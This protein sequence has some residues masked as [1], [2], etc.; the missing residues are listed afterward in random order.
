MCE[1]VG[2]DESVSVGADLH[3]LCQI[4]T[5]NMGRG[6]DPVTRQLPDVKLVNCQDSVNLRHQLLLQGV[7]LDVCGNG[8]QEDQGGLNEERPDGLENED[9]EEEG[10]AGVHVQFVLKLSLPHYDG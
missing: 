6:D 9:D 10:E 7:H 3:V 5:P 8:L 4:E 2:V 1:I